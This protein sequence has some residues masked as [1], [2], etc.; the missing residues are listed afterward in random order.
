M[1][2][3]HR[4][5]ALTHANSGGGAFGGGIIR[6]NTRLY[7]EYTGGN[8]AHTHG[9][10]DSEHSHTVQASAVSTVP[11]FYKLIYCVKLPGA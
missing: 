3:S 5:G 4:H 1:L 9:I 2:A 11:P 10:T 8:A 7:T 6:D